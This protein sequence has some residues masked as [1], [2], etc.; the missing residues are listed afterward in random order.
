MRKLHNWNAWIGTDESGKGDYFGPLVVA[1]V[2]IDNVC[3][4]AFLEMDVSDGK[5]ISN[6]RVKKLANWMWEHF[7]QNIKVTKKMPNV[8]NIDYHKFRL[9]GKNLNS[10][11]ASM[12]VDV[13][14]KLSQ[15]KGAKHVLVDKFSYHDIVSSQ[16]KREHIEVK[17]ETK[18]ER[19][20]AVAAASIIARDTFLTEIDALSQEF[21]LDLPRGANPIVKDAARDFIRK[22]GR[23]ALRNVAKLHFKTTQD[24]L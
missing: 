1:G 24:V 12:H 11:L 21:N 18:A 10:L 14:Q 3:I 15:S 20:I 6:S 4:D 23:S 9:Q 8:Y 16:L 2:Y 7:E 5:R 17:L 13:I 22:H 19:D